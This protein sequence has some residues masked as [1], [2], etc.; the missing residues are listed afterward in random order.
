MRK[1]ILLVLLLLD[2]PLRAD[3]ASL[4]RD[5]QALKDAGIGTDG[6]GLFAFFRQHTAT[7][8]DE[9][10]IRKLV[11]DLGDERF[12]IREKASQELLKIGPRAVQYLKEALTNKDLEVVRRAEKC[13]QDIGKGS[14]EN[15]I[16]AAAR[17]VAARKP[18]GADRVLLDYLGSTDKDFLAE[19]TLEALTQL[20]VVEGKPNA[21]LVGAL[22]DKNAKRR[23]GAALALTKAGAKESREAV[24]KLLQD[25]DVG[26]RV[27]VGLALLG[28]REKEALPVLIR[29]LS[30]APAV[31]A[32]QIE[33][34]LYRLAGDDAPAAEE[35][36]KKQQAAWEKWLK[37]K[38][39]KID[40]AKL[41]EA[42]KLRGL[43]L[44]VLLNAGR[45]QEI[46]AAKNIR[47]KVEGLMFPLDAQRLP[48]ERVLIAEY[49][50][51]R[52]TERNFKGEVVWEKKLVQPI[53]AQRLPNGN[54]F[55]ATPT[56]LVEYDKTGK[57]V[58]TQP[59]P[60]AGR[61]MK[62]T[63]L[64]NGDTAVIVLTGGIAARFHQIDRDGKE[65]RSFA[66]EQRTSGGRVEVLANGHLLIT[67]RDNNRIVELNLE[68]KMT[69]Q[70]RYDQP[71]SA[72][73]LPNG[74]TLVTSMNQQRAVEL[75]KS[76]KEV[77]EYQ[78]D[79]RVTRAWRY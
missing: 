13:I 39:D 21:V 75:D 57:E 64:R 66:V 45:V 54:T 73:R 68:G 38:G 5:E 65:K 42:V 44:L 7:D 25:A 76:G 71:V 28:A 32:A 59:P 17:V 56:Q 11:K 27:K 22:A 19:A 48:G 1:G 8:N 55:I 24:R 58:W 36:R 63:R 26:V 41:D 51:A 79:S 74:N 18:E 16:A 10:A 2:A 47:W 33:D 77:W 14:S 31:E 49:E 40:V 9:A 3:E 67:E 69:W 70:A 37:D 50:G 61:I 20:A 43:T 62:A 52:V 4:Q 6:P 34:M 60:G 12:R 72:V 29:A 23:A 78:A 46:D 53:A 30:E 15:L 35:D